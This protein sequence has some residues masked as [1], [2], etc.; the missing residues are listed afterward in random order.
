MLKKTALQVLVFSLLL[1]PATV[2][3]VRAASADCERILASE[4]TSAEERFSKLHCHILGK[5]HEKVLKALVDMSEAPSVI[6]DYL[7][8]YEAEATLGLGKKERAKE[9]F[10][11]LLVRH[12]DSALRHKAR[13]R[14]AEIHLEGG[15]YSEAARMYLLLVRTTTSRWEKA[16][17]LKN[18]GHIKE[19]QG[20]SEAAMEIFKRIW[21]EHPE[22]SFSDY[23]FTLYKKNKKV[24]IPSPRQ[25]EKRAGIMFSA[26]NWKGALEAF[27][28]APS[29]KA[30]RIKTGICLYR[31]SRFSEALEIFSRIDSPKAFY[32]KGITLERMGKEEEAIGVFELLG[33]LNPKSSWTAKSLLKAARL[34]HLREER[35]EAQRLY[36]LI[37][38][39][40]PGT[41]EAR[42][43]AWNLGWIHYRN[44]EYTK[45]IEIFS[46]SAWAG[47]T[48]QQRFLYWYARAAEKSGDKPGAL[49]A[50]GQLAGSREI[51]Y[52]SFLAKIRLGKKILPPLPTSAA[53]R[54]PFGKTRAIDRF[55][56]LVK[57]GVYDLALD[58]AELL[59][60]LANTREQ[61]AHLASLYLRAGDYKSSI[62][63]A[64]GTLSSESM[65]FAFPKGFE[66]QVRPFSRKY[67][68]DEF[69]VYSLI[70]EESHFNKDA[71]SVSDA[72]G[73]MQILPS[74]AL[75]VAPKAGLSDFE[76]S[77]LFSPEINIDIGCY[78]L[79]WLLDIFDGNIVVSLA[80]Y[81]G[82]PTNARAWYEKNG[83]LDIDEFIEEIPFEQSRNYVKKIIRSYA[84]YEAVYGKEKDQFSRQSFEKFLSI[85]S[86]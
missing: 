55:L 24:F 32:W 6:E 57:A 14:L 7:I 46:D 41:E 36:S 45:A 25:S 56:F 79:N 27:S 78:Y 39:K 64:S 30:V 28:R 9:L 60:P 76:T 83:T 74:T 73:L 71:V 75:D 67:S 69:L 4:G 44:Q 43:S 47:G 35:E 49:F 62:S 72:R 31:L 13:R 52:Y 37:A 42:Q 19:K 53:T 80:G 17:Y 40:Y 15:R 66:K 38:S 3:Q 2:S 34:R 20:N 50:L 84:A 63:M 10:L 23:V 61:R 54:N 86:P 21:T 12:K 26:G 22:V 59:R 16:S 65:H 85:M 81:N 33:K 11:N 8:Y 58:E 1:F 5:Q 18:L 82:G 77:R 70:R 29:T 68:L 48:G 51:T